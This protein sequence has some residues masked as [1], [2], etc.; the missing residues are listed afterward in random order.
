MTDDEPNPWAKIVGPCYTVASMARALEWTETEV[1][2]AGSDLRLLM[3]HTSDDVY[4]F[5]SFQLQEGSIVEGLQE[6]LRVLATGTA[7]S[8]TWAQWL[9]VAL[10]DEDPPRN[11]TLLYEGRLEEALRDAK[12][13]AWAWRS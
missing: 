10:P 3:L 4:L 6:V 8:W 5:P 13:D 9:N 2:E 11:I 12:H 1:M 7:D